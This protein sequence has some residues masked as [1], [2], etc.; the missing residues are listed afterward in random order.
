MSYTVN[1][2]DV[3]TRQD[4]ITL[5]RRCG[6]IRSIVA[7]Q[8]VKESFERGRAERESWSQIR[9][10]FVSGDEE[11]RFFDAHAELLNEPGR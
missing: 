10:E 3:T 7:A 1:V 11:N 6:R 9:I 8:S 5:A 4:I 2:T